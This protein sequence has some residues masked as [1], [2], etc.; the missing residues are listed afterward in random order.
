MFPNSCHLQLTIV[1]Q[2]KL[3]LLQHITL[4]AKPDLRC[5]RTVKRG[6]SNKRH[7][8]SPRNHPG[9]FCKTF[10]LRQGMY[11]SESQRELFSTFK[12]PRRQVRLALG[13]IRGPAVGCPSTWHLSGS[14]FSKGG[15]EKHMKMRSKRYILLNHYCAPL[16]KQRVL[17][18][19]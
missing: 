16:Q 6:P 1:W 7:P 15:E 3:P 14:T 13:L 12:C 8:Y 10:P 18:N 11:D 17:T 9:L 5:R 4:S 2:S 19:N